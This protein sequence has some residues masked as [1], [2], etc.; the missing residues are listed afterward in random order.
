MNV[1]SLHNKSRIEKFLRTQNYLNI[2]SIGDLDKFFW[3]YTNWYALE[4]NGKIYAIVLKYLGSAI[5]SI[6]A[7]CVASETKYTQTLLKSLLNVLPKK[8]YAHFS[9]GL[10]KV[11]SDE[12]TLLSSVPHLKMG[13]T[14][15]EQLN[16][17]T[18]D[19]E[20]KCLG[21]ND[22]NKLNTL[23]NKAYPHNWFDKRMIQTGQYYGIL[24]DNMVVSVAGIH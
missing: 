6:L 17:H 8:F 18:G 13:L 19:V 24:K 23:Y 21:T 2:Y 11:I 9:F 3:N 14:Q 16:V 10:A 12:Y 5:P 20:I 7:F 15:K 4:E 22:I 1:I